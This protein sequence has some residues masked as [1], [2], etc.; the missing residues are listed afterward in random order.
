MTWLSIPILHMG[1][2]RQREIKELPQGD[3]ASKSQIWNL[4]L[5]HLAPKTVHLAPTHMPSVLCILYTDT[6]KS[7]NVVIYKCAHTYTH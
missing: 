3:P 6:H 7:T 1:K 4:N 2:M 5:G